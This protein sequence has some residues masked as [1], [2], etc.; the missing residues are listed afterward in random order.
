MSVAAQRR[1]DGVPDRDMRVPMT[2]QGSRAPLTL[3]VGQHR[4]DCVGKAAGTFRKPVRRVQR[5]VD[6]DRPTICVAGVEDAPGRDT[7]AVVERDGQEGVGVEMRVAAGCQ[8]N[9]PPSGRCHRGDRRDASPS[10]QGSVAA[11]AIKRPDV[12][13]RC[14]PSGRTSMAMATTSWQSPLVH[15][16]DPCLAAVR[17]AI[18]SGAAITQPMRKPG[19][20]SFDVVPM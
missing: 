6:A 13:E 20:S 17:A 4:A 3:S 14:G 2:R 18:I 11:G 7:D 10:P 16:S 9:I 12:G 1:T 15:M 8:T 5:E 19:A